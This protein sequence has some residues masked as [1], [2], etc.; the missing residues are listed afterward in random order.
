MSDYLRLVEGFVLRKTLDE[1]VAV[2]CGQ[3]ALRMPGLVSMNE[4]GAF[5]FSALLEEHTEDSLKSLLLENYDTDEETAVQDVRIFVE[6][7][8]KKNLLIEAE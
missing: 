6:H 8:R 4:T 7:L 2:S 3:S 5:L 1:W